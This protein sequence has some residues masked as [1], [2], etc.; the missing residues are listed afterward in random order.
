MKHNNLLDIIGNTP[1]VRLNIDSPATIYAK[2]EYLNPGGSLKDRSALFLIEQAERKGLLKPGGTI[3]DASS[4]NHGIA[5]AMI[6]ALK[7]YKVIITATSKFSP[8]K[9][10]NI[11]AYG[12]QV[13]L[14]EPT[15]L[16]SDPN[17]YHNVAV[18]LHKET[19][20]S[21]MPNQYYNTDNALAHYTLLAPEIWRQ[22]EGKIT[23]FFAAAG[24]GGVVSGVGKY[25][26]EKNSAINIIALD[27][28][29][30]YHATKGN[31]KPYKVE[32]MGLD[33]DNEIL[34]ES[35]IDDFFHITDN[36]ALDMLPYLASQHGLLVGPTSGAVAYA[37][38][39]YA[40]RL[41]KD[42][43][44][45]L[46]FGDSGRSYF[47]KYW[48]TEELGKNTLPEITP[49]QKTEQFQL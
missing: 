16:A 45:V 35:V 13:V 17:S 19:P 26:K 44:A 14:C 24:T 29:N 2:L 36:Q 27:S 25:L 30:S 39:E 38:Q 43:C 22:T 31:P 32:G 28:I 8:E 48:S 4:G 5:V 9:M 3:I 1:L 15:D 10:A 42:D 11:R 41:T 20:N 46:I 49:A 12:A 18:R 23:H 7:G 6:G 33:F 21:F 40:K 47:S 34:N 37:A